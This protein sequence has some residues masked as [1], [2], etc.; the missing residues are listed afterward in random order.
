[1]FATHA[2]SIGVDV[3]LESGILILLL[4]ETQEEQSLVESDTKDFKCTSRERKSEWPR[5]IKTVLAVLVTRTGTIKLQRVLLYSHCVRR[6][7]N[8]VLLS[9]RS[10]LNPHFKNSH[11]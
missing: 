11:F 5:A 2:C 3:G 1:M 9:F 4:I 7:N 8:L 6:R 10:D